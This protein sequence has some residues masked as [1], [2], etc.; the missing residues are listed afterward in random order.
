[1]KVKSSPGQP[2]YLISGTAG[3]RLNCEVKIM[4]FTSV[5]NILVSPIS[6]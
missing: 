1:M 2:D 6:P 4:I 5:F 3:S